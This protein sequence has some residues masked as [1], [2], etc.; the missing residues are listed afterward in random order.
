MPLSFS[1][2]A[3]KALGFASIG[4]TIP[5]SGA[6]YSFVSSPFGYAGLPYPDSPAVTV[7][8]VLLE[9]SNNLNANSF[10]FYVHG[11]GAGIRPLISAKFQVHLILMVGEHQY[12]IQ[13]TLGIITLTEKN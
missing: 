6:A 8:P 5:A 10:T 2:G 13:V 7:P 9:T 11:A 12:T 1:T 4:N 3:S